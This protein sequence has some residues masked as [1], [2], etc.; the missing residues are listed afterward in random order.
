[1]KF[2]T[3]RVVEYSNTYKGL[4]VGTSKVDQ[5]AE[6]IGVP[7]SEKNP[8]KLEYN[9]EFTVFFNNRTGA[10]DT[11]TITDPAYLDANGL[12][13][14]DHKQ[15]VI[16][17]KISGLNSDSKTVTDFDKGIVYWFDDAD[18]IEKIV[19]AHKLLKSTFAQNN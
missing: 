10:I 2:Y 7:I 4:E 17:S 8:D 19:L 6:L 12:Q 13:V 1:M 3:T 16:K 14:G 9:D 18:R 11:I 5:V 15:R